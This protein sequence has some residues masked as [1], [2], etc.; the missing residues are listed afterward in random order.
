MANTIQAPGRYSD[1]QVQVLR[2]LPIFGNAGTTPLFTPLIGTT[3]A[4]DTLTSTLEAQGVGFPIIARQIVYAIKTAATEANNKVLLDMY[5]NTT[6]NGRLSI[7]AEA[8]LTVNTSS[9][10]NGTVTAGAYLRFRNLAS[11]TASDG[12]SAIGFIGVI[13]SEYEI[14]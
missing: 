11:H 9:A 5:I 6:S 8:A 4:A 7:D 10:I 2:Y 3:A 12:Q 14:A 1:A 13:Y